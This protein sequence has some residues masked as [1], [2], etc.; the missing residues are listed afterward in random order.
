MIHLGVSGMGMVG[1]ILNGLLVSN[2]EVLPELFELGKVVG[3]EK[4]SLLEVM[5]AG[6]VHS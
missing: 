5:A 3:M 1:M 6:T 4:D 2:S